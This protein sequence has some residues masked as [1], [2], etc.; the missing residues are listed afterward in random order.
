MKKIKG[1]LS[2]DSQ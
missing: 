1:Y 2:W